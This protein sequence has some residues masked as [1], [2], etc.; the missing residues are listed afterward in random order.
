MSD[1]EGTLHTNTNEPTVKIIK[2]LDSMPNWNC[3]ASTNDERLGHFAAAGFG[4]KISC[5]LYDYRFWKT[6]SADSSLDTLGS[7]KT[8]QFVFRINREDFVGCLDELYRIAFGFCLFDTLCNV[9]FALDD[10]NRG[11]FLRKN[12]CYLVN[13]HEFFPVSLASYL[14]FPYDIPDPPFSELRKSSWNEGS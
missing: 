13:P 10:Q 7:P 2:W 12:G 5:L 11:V 4:T 6:G 9:R 1:F 3:V 8:V 14:I